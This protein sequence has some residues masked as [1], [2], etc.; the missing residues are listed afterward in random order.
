M[1]LFDEIRCDYPL[2]DD[3]VPQDT[4]FET[5]C[6]ECGLEEHTITAQGRLILHRKHQKKAGTHVRL[7][8][9]WPKYEVDF[10]EDVDLD[11]HGDIEIYGSRPGKKKLASYIVRFTHGTVEYI[12]PRTKSDR[13]YGGGWF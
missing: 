6:L 1:G 2:P 11:F 7:G 9:P 13:V 3:R 10:V 12:R 8:R 5:K 4:V